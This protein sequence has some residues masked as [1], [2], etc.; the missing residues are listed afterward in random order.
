MSVKI[1]LKPPLGKILKP[2]ITDGD[3]ESDADEPLVNAASVVTLE[4]KET[5]LDSNSTADLSD[6]DPIA[7]VT[8]DVTTL[9]NATAAESDL[10]ETKDP[11][12]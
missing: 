4:S 6:V 5:A 10:S 8:L 12:R 3:A 2:P 9:S 1:L 11:K 7:P